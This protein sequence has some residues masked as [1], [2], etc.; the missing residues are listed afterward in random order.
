MKKLL[1]L[2]V[3]WIS[4]L[5]FSSSAFAGSI[6]FNSVN[7]GGTQWRYDYTVND[8]FIGNTNGFTIYFDE[9]LYENLANG[10]APSSDWD[11][12]LIQP[13]PSVPPSIPP[14]PGIFDGLASA[15]LPAGSY[16]FSVEF[17]WL[18]MGTSAPGS[19][20]YELYTLDTSGYVTGSKPGWTSPP[21]TVP[22]PSSS[23]ILLGIGFSG[24]AIARR[25]F[26]QR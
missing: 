2:S 25:K 5:A 11:L 23:L 14:A 22:E 12:L 8:S 7:L 3:I 19:Q 20:P 21:T 15:T 26:A 24:V 10:T 18:G 9:S 16:S 13:Q 4:V 17:T 1:L 6:Q